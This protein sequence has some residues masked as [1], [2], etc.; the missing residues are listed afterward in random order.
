M[1]RLQTHWGGWRGPAPEHLRPELADHSGLKI[2][3]E[4]DPR[5]TLPPIFDQ[6]QLGSCTANAT[7]AAFQYDHILDGNGNPPAALSRLWIYYQERKLEGSLGQ[8]DTG[9][10]GHDA[11]KVAST[12]G[13]P[14]EADWPYD[15]ST[16]AGPVP[17]RAVKDERYY[18]LRRPYR[19]VTPT[20]EAFKAVLSNRQTIAFG[21]SVYSSFE[22]QQVANTGIVPMPNVRREQLLG[23]HE[24]LLVGYLKAYP[25]YG[26]VRN[27]WNTGWGLRGYCLMPWDL[28]VSK[29][30]AGDWTTIVRTAGH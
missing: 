8:G 5:G 27:S 30:L 11:F 2:L 16:Y 17:A 21:F 3:D 14:A 25:D 1:T 13:V 10:Y 26:L 19:S 12:I 4:V 28:L 23:G 22:S 15:I 29:K 9:A 6:G 18:V 7:A 20:V 24:P